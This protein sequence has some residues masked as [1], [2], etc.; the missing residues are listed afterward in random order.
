MRERILSTKLVI[1]S[2][3]QIYNTMTAHGLTSGGSVEMEQR[4]STEDRKVSMKGDIK[5]L[6][7]PPNSKG[8]ITHVHAT[9]TATDLFHL[10]ALLMD[11][12]DS[13]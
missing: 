10:L 7:N 3:C 12:L 5:K 13:P 1:T 11:I 2:I 6:D 4:T 8:K 9:S